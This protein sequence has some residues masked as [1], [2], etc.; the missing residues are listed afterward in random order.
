MQTL[1]ASDLARLLGREESTIKADAN[2]R[3]HT[4]PPRLHIP[5]TR[6]LLWLE[7]DVHAWLRQQREPAV[8]GQP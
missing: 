3:P 1:K 4:L 2:R 5:G 8:K 6:S 7:E